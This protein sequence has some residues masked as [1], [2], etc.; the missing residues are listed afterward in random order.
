MMSSLRFNTPHLLLNNQDRIG[1]CSCWATRRADV[2]RH[3][4]SNRT[5]AAPGLRLVFG[6][7]VVLVETVQQKMVRGSL[8]RSG[9]TGFLRMGTL[10]METYLAMMDAGQGSP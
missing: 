3:A 8:H 4:W 1:N 6:S 2:S 7:L 10:T 9:C 5:V